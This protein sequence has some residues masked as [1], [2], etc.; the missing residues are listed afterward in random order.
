MIV[1]LHVLTNAS[2]YHSIVFIDE[3]TLKQW[4]LKL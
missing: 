3:Q 4:K 2:F 1:V